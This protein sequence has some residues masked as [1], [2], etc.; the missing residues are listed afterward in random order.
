MK[1]NTI[2]KTT[3][4]CLA[5]A[6]TS[7]IPA[8]AG[9]DNGGPVTKPEPTVVVEVN[10]VVELNGGCTAWYIGDSRFV[11]AGH[12]ADNGTVLK[13]EDGK[14]IS[15]EFIASATI[16]NGMADWAVLKAKSDY[17]TKNM[18]AFEL[19]C[20]YSPKIG[21]AVRLDGYPTDLGFWVS[22]GRVASNKASK[23]ANWDKP[24]IRLDITAYKGNSGSPAILENSGKVFGILVGG[25]AG[26]NPSMTVVQPLGPLCEAL[27]LGD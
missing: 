24:V 9:V 14:S 20:D 12:C 8:I 23:W 1:P 13:T 21:D 11:T 2:L 27:N 25:D 4:L 3:Y 22:F 17:V 7:V 18:K 26:G 10:P 16:E 6:M 5:I 19:D 15:A